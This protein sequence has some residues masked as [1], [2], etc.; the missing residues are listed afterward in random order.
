MKRLFAIGAIALTIALSACAQTSDPVSTDSTAQEAQAFLAAVR[1]NSLES[2][3]SFLRSYPNR[4]FAAQARIFEADCLRAICPS[5]DT[6]QESFL[7]ARVTASSAPQATPSN[8]A[9]ERSIAY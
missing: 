4:Q 8:A 9:G 1:A 3:Q 7:L 5:S 6:I 2:Y